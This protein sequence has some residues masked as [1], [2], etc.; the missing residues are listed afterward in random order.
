[1]NRKRTHIAILLLMVLVSL[2]TACGGGNGGGASP[3]EGTQGQGNVQPTSA[4]TG[5][6]T[7][8]QPTTG[9]QPT[10]QPAA[11]APQATQEPTSTPKPTAAK[12]TAQKGGS[13]V[14]GTTEEP[15]TLNPYLT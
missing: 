13:L 8:G 1:M 9:T 6:G 14:I 2:L 10:S 4:D 3:T 11:N 15:D 7:A 12:E 5:G